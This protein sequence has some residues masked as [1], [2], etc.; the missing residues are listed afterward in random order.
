MIITDN[1]GGELAALLAK[2]QSN[3]PD[4]PQKSDTTIDTLID[5][6]VMLKTG[7]VM[8]YTRDTNNTM[9][10]MPASVKHNV[11]KELPLCG[12]CRTPIL[13]TSCLPCNLGRD[14]QTTV[15]TPQDDTNPFS[16]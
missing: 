5:Y 13:G 15:N 7:E 6:A 10:T 12:G 16:F 2:P 8:V 3:T 11:L 14:V 4:N 1:I 9:D